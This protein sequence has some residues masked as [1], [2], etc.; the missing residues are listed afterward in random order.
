MAKRRGSPSSAAMVRAV[1]S[2]IPRKQR[3]RWTRGRRGARSRRARRSCSTACSRATASSTVRR[4]A[5]CVWSSAGSGHVCARSHAKCRGPRLL[6]RGVAAAVAQQEFRKAMPRP[7]Q[8]GA[9]VFP[10]AQQIPRRFLLARRDVDRGQRARAIEHGEL[11]R[12]ASIRL[13]PV[14]RRGAE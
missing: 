10:A 8:I 6:G 3:R 13:D 12:I 14:A 7:Q 2:S 11:A 5:R 4:Y 9:N 1:R